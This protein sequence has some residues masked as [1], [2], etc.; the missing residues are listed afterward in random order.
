M[1]LVAPPG[2]QSLAPLDKSKHRNVGVRAHAA[3]FA[4][5]LQTIYLTLAEFVPASRH[6]PIVFAKDSGECM[7]AFAVV[8]VE[9]GHNLAT[10]AQGDWLPKTYCPAYVRRYPF[11]TTQV[12]VQ[13]TTKALI[14]VDETG[15]ADNPPHLFDAQGE[16]TP[17]WRE[18]QRF[19]EEVDAAQTLTLTFCRELE[20]LGLLEP[21]V[22]DLNPNDGPHRRIDG[23]LRVREGALR[24]LPVAQLAELV[25]NGYLP[26]I[27]AHLMS[28]DNFHHLLQRR[29]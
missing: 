1:S 5:S 16:A 3:R 18:V 22:A 19:I 20:R 7:H 11:W 8:G 2:Y 4:A 27:Y 6:F 17:R 13:G 12:T 24:Q 23:M 9:T 25:Q 10:D 29:M 14:C 28:H 21:F 26:R 15:L